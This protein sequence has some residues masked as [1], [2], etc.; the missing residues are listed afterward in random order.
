M[1]QDLIKLKKRL[2]RLESFSDGEIVDVSGILQEL[3]ELL[4]EKETQC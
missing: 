1:K 3:I 2:E 4:I